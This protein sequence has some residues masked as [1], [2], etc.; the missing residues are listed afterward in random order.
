MVKINWELSARIKS[1]LEIFDAILGAKWNININW[2][3][4]EETLNN[5]VILLSLLEKVKQ[6]KPKDWKPWKDGKPWKD[7][8]DWKPWK[9]GNDWEDWDNWNDWDNWDNWLS[10]YEIAIKNGFIWTE[11]EWLE[12]LK[13]K[14]W[15]KWEKGYRWVPWIAWNEIN[16]ITNITWDITVKPEYHKIIADATNNDIVITLPNASW[17]YLQEFIITRIDS[18]S[19]NVTIEA[20]PWET[21]VFV[22]RQSIF[23]YNMKHLFFHLIT[24][25]IYNYEFNKRNTY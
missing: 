19:Y 20:K 8:E 22:E 16:N 11:E 17:L 6:Q 9:D 24:L 13:W 10:A 3:I 18:S 7:W 23:T 5:I 12:S 4:D 1:Q 15:D 2:E 25:T 21:L 14:N